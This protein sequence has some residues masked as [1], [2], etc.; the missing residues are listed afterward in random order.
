MT[1]NREFKKEILGDF[2]GLQIFEGFSVAQVIVVESKQGFEPGAATSLCPVHGLLVE[3][4]DGEEEVDNKK[5]LNA[6][7]AEEE[8]ELEMT[9]CSEE[10]ITYQP[11]AK[12]K[13]RP[14]KVL[15]LTSMETKLKS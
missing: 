13:F 7:K 3:S 1:Q 6:K 9:E 4:K 8:E 2:K 15:H 5:R 14:S 11:V 10:I 12:H